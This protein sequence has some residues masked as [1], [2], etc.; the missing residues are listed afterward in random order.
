MSLAS[1]Q[2]VIG[3]MILLSDPNGEQFI[4][5]K[6]ILKDGSFSNDTNRKLFVTIKR[7]A[8][9]GAVDILTVEDQYN[10][11]FQGENIFPYLADIMKNTPSAANAIEYA[12]IVR[13]ASVERY[14]VAKLQNLIAEF[15]DQSNGDVYQ[16]LGLIETTVD[17]IT[18]LG[19]S[20]SRGGLRHITE[21][22]GSWMDSLEERITQDGDPNK[23]TTGIESLDDAI[24]SK[25][26]RTGS[27]VV[28]GARPK[29]G[30]SALMAS[31]AN[32]FAVDLKKPVAVFSMEMPGDEV[33]ERSL[34]SLGQIDPSMFYSKNTDYD[35]MQGRLGISVTEFSNSNYY[36]SEDVGVTIEQIKSETRVMR[37]EHGHIGLICVDYLT[38]ME[39]PKADRNDLAFGHITKE[40]K[41]L[42]K[43]LQCVVLL[44]TQ[45]NRGLESRSDKRPVP[46]D[47]RDTGHIEQD[48][49]V[50]MGLYREGVYEDCQNPELMEIIVRLNRHGKSGTG[51]ANLKQG[52]LQPLTTDD[53]LRVLSFRD[54]KKKDEESSKRYSYSK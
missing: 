17:S 25:G 32:H 30:K 11:D 35:E 46:S 36:I 1:E 28:I 6:S 27:L 48:C 38:L 5:V 22:A 24:G 54:D 43:E 53:G 3:A 39:A 4:K 31:M 34:T 29:M 37:K 7:V 13:D 15:S 2:S 49:D 47:S 45:L 8:S 23:H 12:R 52:F 42:A 33:F 51:F 16:R 21:F 41:K 26:I 20:E 14:A 50:W 19:M 9:K 18:N 10:K 44:L 40:L